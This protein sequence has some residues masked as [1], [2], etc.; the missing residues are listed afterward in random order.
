[1]ICYVLG[2]VI[3]AA[4]ALVGAISMLRRPADGSQRHWASLVGGVVLVLVAILALGF[5]ACWGAFMYGG[6]LG[7]MH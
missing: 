6:G 4:L 7:N 3:F 2:P 1:M 5:G